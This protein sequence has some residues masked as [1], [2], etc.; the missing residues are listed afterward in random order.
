MRLYFITT[1]VVLIET[2]ETL[3]PEIKCCEPIN[4]ICYIRQ[5]IDTFAKNLYYYFK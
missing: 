3:N 1:Y 5:E 4:I 2:L